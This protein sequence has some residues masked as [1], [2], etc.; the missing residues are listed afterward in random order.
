MENP[1]SWCGCWQCLSHYDTLRSSRLFAGIKTNALTMDYD[2]GVFKRSTL[3]FLIEAS[4]SLRLWD[5]QKSFCR[6]RLEISLMVRAKVREV[7][8]LDTGWT[9]SFDRLYIDSR[10]CIFVSLKDDEPNNKNCGIDNEH[11]AGPDV[12]CGRRKSTRRV[13]VDVSRSF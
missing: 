4:A 11:E 9:A 3:F 6:R 10:Q 7:K 5:Y 13:E 1:V 2:Y 8:S 12:V